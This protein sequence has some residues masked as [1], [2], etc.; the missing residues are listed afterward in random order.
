[1]WALDL[2]LP[3]SIALFLL[4]FD[5]RLSTLPIAI[6]LLIQLISS[7]QFS[8]LVLWP[9]FT[10]LLLSTRVWWFNDPPHPASINDV[11]LLLSGVVAGLSISPRRWSRL[12]FFPVIGF[13]PT[14]F[15]F[16]SK[17]WTPNPFIGANQ[18]A[19][20]FGLF[21]SILSV[22]SLVNFKK[23]FQLWM[24]LPLA[25]I[26]FALLWQ[27]G[28][29][30][31]LVSAIIASVIPYVMCQ[32]RE[33]RLWKSVVVVTAAMAFIYILRVILS[34]NPGLPGFKSGSDLGRLMAYD[35]FSRLPFTGNNRFIYGVGFDRVKELCQVDFQGLILDH[36]H[37][38]YLQVW[39]ST[40]ILGIL[41]IIL[42]VVFL[43]QQYKI[44]YT[45]MPCDLQS[46]WQ[47]VCI[48]T[49]AQGFFDASLLHWPVT[50]MVT[51]IFLGIPLSFRSL[52]FR[53]N[54]A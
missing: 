45:H 22:W 23:Y 46:C 36:A 24:A 31:A 13:L 53:P 37:N 32:A 33:Y 51:G 4:P 21:L 40:G 52:S 44:A 39:A 48:Y 7:D 8:R 2:L 18:G 26:V 38:L 41:A 5:P 30:A 42:L 54:T 34:S 20:V 29:R 14:L 12:L 19:Y 28:S 1:M 15:T 50:L 25:V 16:S 43:V 10:L 3:C 35:C 6:W 17:P 27:T 9:W 11:V 47:A 49:L